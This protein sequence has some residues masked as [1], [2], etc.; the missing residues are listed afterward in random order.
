M[1]PAAR[2]Q[3]T[4]EILHTVFEG[5]K[6]ADTITTQY[7]KARRYAGSKDRRSINE[8]VY[9][10][11]RHRAKLAWMADQVSWEHEPRQL[12]LIDCLLQDEEVSA[13]FT[14]DQY[15]PAP[16]HPKEENALAVLSEVNIEKAPDHVRF[17]YPEWL[18]TDLRASLRGHFEATLNAL[19]TEAPL[20]LRVNGLHTDP[21]NVIDLLQ[22]QNIDVTKGEYSPYCLRSSKKIKLAG[23]KVYKDGLVDIQ[24][25]G[26]Q[27]IALLTEA[28]DCE[29]VMDFCAG[30]GGKT[31]ALAAEMNNQG[32][33]YAL[34]ISPKRLFKMRPRLE[35]AGATNVELHPIKSESDPWLKQFESRVE[36]LL[37]DAPCSGVG[38]WR[39]SPE[40]RWKMTSELLEDLIGR[41]ERI[42]ETAAHMVKPGGRL[43]YATCSLLKRENE[44]QIEKFLTGHPD[45]HIKPM[46]D[47]WGDVL[48]TPSPFDGNFMSMR[49]DLH[50]SDGFFCAVLERKA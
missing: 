36:R 41:Q 12:V 26:S 24:D 34:D 20:D 39:R 49:P 50:R 47:V 33:L 5:Q 38:A 40:S 30:A 22:Q 18:D 14:G 45:Y 25:E 29:L 32:M 42:L 28:K 7:F 3:S 8:R 37:I 16:L 10:I 19:N 15:C 9:R 6:P 21:S 13:L 35:R 4:I 43:I 1:K 31:L 23:L 17:E 2:L 44:E 48:H 46:S 11:L 27:L